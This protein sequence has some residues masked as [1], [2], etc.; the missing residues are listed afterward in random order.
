MDGCMHAY[1]NDVLFSDSRRPRKNYS[2]FIADEQQ[3]NQTEVLDNDEHV[4][5]KDDEKP[6]NDAT[7]ANDAMGNGNDFSDDS[8]DYGKLPI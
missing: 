1:K 5:S 4:D 2:K 6:N 3:I 8:D 7:F